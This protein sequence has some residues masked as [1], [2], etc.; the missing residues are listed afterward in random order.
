[1]LNITITYDGEEGIKVSQIDA[2]MKQLLKYIEK[3][4]AVAKE[5]CAYGHK[6]GMIKQMIEELIEI[7]K[8]GQ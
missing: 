5:P 3:W 1:M 7:M 4:T 2:D 6:C 8:I